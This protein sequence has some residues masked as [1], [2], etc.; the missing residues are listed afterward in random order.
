MITVWWTVE[1]GGRF[2]A[3]IDR[4]VF[5]ADYENIVD[6]VSVLAFPLLFVPVVS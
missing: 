4:W 3:S 5:F 2:Y 1:L 6:L